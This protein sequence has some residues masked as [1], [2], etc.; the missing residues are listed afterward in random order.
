M[1]ARRASEASQYLLRAPFSLE[2][3]TWNEKTRKVIYRSKRSWHTKKNYQIFSATDFIAATVEHI[4]PK[5]QQC[6]AAQAASKMAKRNSHGRSRRRSQTVR[7]YGLYSNKSRGL[8]AKLGSPRPQLRELSEAARAVPAD[9]TLFPLPAAEAKS[10]RALRPLWRDLIMKVWGEDPLLCPCCKGTM[11][12][13]G[14]MIRRE[15]VDCPATASFVACHEPVS[16]CHSR[17]QTR[18]ECAEGALNFTCDS[19]DCGTG[20]SDCLRRPTRLLTSKRW[21][22]LMSHRNGDGA[23]KSAR[24][25]RTGGSVRRLCGRHPSSTL[26]MAGSL[27]SM[28]GIRFRWTIYRSS[29][30][31]DREIPPQH[32]F[33]PGFETKTERGRLGMP[34]PLG[35]T[36]IPI[37][38]D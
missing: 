30:T 37:R 29:R 6:H 3:I 14:T 21:S 18:K 33:L 34:S 25:P 31:T 15:D 5:S 35:F 11:R 16:H 22:R 26:G 2:K 17:R 36:I 4:P 28:S 9:P 20:S 7:Y 8:A 1:A 38:N 23:M 32:V 19:T 10:A 12:V 27:S 13:V 24:H